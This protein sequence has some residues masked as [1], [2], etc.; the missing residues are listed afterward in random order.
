M[1]MFTM[2][3]DCNMKWLL[4]MF[5]LL[6][7][8]TLLCSS[9]VSCQNDEG[10]CYCVKPDHSEPNSTN[11]CQSDDN[12]T[13]PCQSD[14]NSTDLPCPCE[15]GCHS[16]M[17]YAN[18][19]KTFFK[20]NDS[21]FYFLPGTHILSG[22]PVRVIAVHNLTLVGYNNSTGNSFCNSASVSIPAATVQCQGNNTGFYFHYIENLSITGIR[23]NDCGFVESSKYSNA[24]LMSFVCNLC[25]HGVEIHRARGV[26]LY[27]Y[28]I[29]GDSIISNTVIDSSKNTSNFSGG[30]L[31]VYY[32]TDKH[33][34]SHSSNLTVINTTILNGE[35]IA[36]VASHKPYSGGLDIYLDTTDEIQIFLK[37]VTLAG[38]KGYDG[39]NAAITY[40]AQNN[41]WPSSITIHNCSFHN[42]I[43]RSLGGGLYVAL[44]AANSGG[45]SNHSSSIVVLSVT[46]SWFCSN[47]AHIV[48]AGVYIQLHEN[49][50]FS[51]VALMS[52]T[53]C[54]FNSNS[55]LSLTDR[56]GGSAVNMINFR[57]PDYVPHRSP[58]YNVSFTACLFTDN[59]APVLSSDSVGSGAFY[60][61]ENAVTVLTDCYFA[62]NKCTG[63]SAVHSNLVLQGNITIL[64]NTAVNGGGMVMCANSIMYLATDV[65]V[66]IQDN[67]ATQSGGGIYAEFEC[68]QAIPPCFFQVY[69]TSNAQLSTRVYNNTAD[70]SGSAIYGGSVDYCYYF[71]PFLNGQSHYRLFDK[72]FLIKS[73]KQNDLSSISSN[74]V[75][76]CFCEGLKP[77]CTKVEKEVNSIHLG[78]EISV[79]VVVVGQRHGT[80]PGVVAARLKPKH[81]VK[82]RLGDLQETQSIDVAACRL[83][84]YAIYSTSSKGLETITLSVRNIDFK[85]AAI[86]N[87]S[88][89]SIHVNIAVC[90]TGFGMGKSECICNQKLQALKNIACNISTRSIHR[91]TISKW[92]VGFK[93]ISDAKNHNMS[94]QTDS[95]TMKIIYNDYCPFDYCVTKHVTIEI[96][97]ISSQDRQC[98][99][100]RTGTLCGSCKGGLSNVL[101]SSECLQCH[102]DNAV[103]ILGLLLFFAVL[104][105]LLVLFL[106]ILNLNVTEGTLNAIVFYTNVVR[107]NTSLFFHSP[108]DHIIVAKWLQVFVAWMNL[109]L[110][111][112]MC[113]YNG[114]EAVGKTALQFV[115]PL[116]LFGLAGLIIYFSRKSPLVMKLAGKNSVKILA[117]IF[118]HSYAKLLRTL[119]DIWR[120]TTNGTTTND[121]ISSKSTTVWAIN[122]NNFLHDKGHAALF[123]LS[124]LMA[125]FTLPYTLALLF[126]QCL[127]KRS[128]MKLLF[129]VNKLKP[130]FDA[131]T[132]PYKDRY[133]FWTG[134]LL[135]V[136]I[137]LFVGV[138]TNTTIGPILNLTLITVTA[139]LLLLLIQPGLYKTWQLT[140]I[141]AFAYF[142]LIVF[143]VGTAYSIYYDHSKD[144]SVIICVG[145][146]F[147]LFC[148]VVVYHVYKKLSDTQRWRKMKVWLLDKKWPWMRRKPIRSLILPHIDTDSDLSS[149]DD[150]LDPVL[151]NAPPVARFDQYREPLIETEENT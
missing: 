135:I 41:S 70:T 48:G 131:Y 71:G 108:R 72:L 64:N 80:V 81:G 86:E 98:A 132:G 106:G 73:S 16:L 107:V 112:H 29:L 20:Q 3:P 18:F 7:A 24:I 13:N 97:N 44:I 31:H 28:Q 124:V 95:H 91:E 137:S 116:Y 111:I 38:N 69:N 57:I 27:G 77:N 142:N 43:A 144:T 139:S 118:L 92:W 122:G 79:S 63:I 56:R 126:I 138:A 65:S 6:F 51:S 26:G 8:L 129:W 99:F 114:M 121:A 88:T 47:V 21:I 14:D 125:G 105:I 40:L 141:E 59:Q 85:N 119:I 35:N 55:I 128:D 74:P 66:L 53:D 22:F 46:D 123:V 83:L 62:H 34:C 87:V 58:Q 17:Y 15:G 104:G 60:V 90:P 82:H 75:R 23:F 110:G 103:R 9:S 147:L 78:A 148:G 136:R 19:S 37:N 25:M 130:F 134:F 117:T 61:E 89:I 133:H 100:N 109:D 11:P 143:S 76:V 1:A 145:S 150:E 113:F 93:N 2:V 67:H 127:R 50:S 101:G 52:F 5:L 36:Y 4:L 140:A 54:H 151:R 33:V 84:H 96:D 102:H 49:S 45:S 94:T 68:T 32:K 10:S 30:N 149:S 42:G 146:M 39:G 120:I 12:S 115:F